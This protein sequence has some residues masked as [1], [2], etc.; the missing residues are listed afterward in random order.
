M[1]FPPP[2]AVYMNSLL[3]SLNMRHPLSNPG[4]TS[5]KRPF[6]ISVND[7][8]AMTAD[9]GIDIQSGQPNVGALTRKGAGRSGVMVE[10]KHDLAPGE[11]KA[12]GLRG[13]GFTDN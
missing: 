5:T 9:Y 11:L 8:M 13:P 12:R 1:I 4:G 3:S 10:R 7:A 6:V 2:P